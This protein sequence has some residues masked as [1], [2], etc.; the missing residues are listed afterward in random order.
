MKSSNEI[1]YPVF[2]TNQI[3][4]ST[5]L[6][7]LREFLDNE[8][9]LTRINIGGSGII[10]GLETDFVAA[11][12]LLTVSKGYGI[13]SD[14]HFIT[15]ETELLLKR[16]KIY[17]LPENDVYAPF[18]KGK[19][20]VEI[21]ELFPDNTKVEGTQPLSKISKSEMNKKVVVLFLE[22]FDERLNTCTGSDCDNKGKRR[23]CSVKVLLINQADLSAVNLG[24]YVNEED[25]LETIVLPTLTYY[26]GKPLSDVTSIREI[27]T[28]YEKIVNEFRKKLSDAILAAHSKY[29]KYFDLH[30]LDIKPA[31]Q[32]KAMTFDKKFSQ[33][34]YDFIRDLILAYNEF[35]D[36]AGYVYREAVYNKPVF[37]RH[38]MLSKVYPATASSIES[39]RNYFVNT[40]FK[41]DLGNKTLQAQI[42]FKRILLM[43]DSF[44]PNLLSKKEIKITPS[45]I[46]SPLSIEAIPYY[47]KNADKIFALWNAELEIKSRSEENLSYNIT[48]SQLDFVKDPL[49][50]RY[51]DKQYY[52]IEGH[53]GMD[54]KKVVDLLEDQKQIYNLDF[55]VIGLRLGK[56]SEIS[57]IK[58]NCLFYRYQLE[59]K[60][61]RENII[62]E[63]DKIIKSIEKEF[64]SVSGQSITGVLL[65]MMAKAS[66]TEMKGKT[67]P[68]DELIRDLTIF[69]EGWYRVFC[70]KD[71]DYKEY[72]KTINFILI[73]M[74]NYYYVLKFL[75]DNILYKLFSNKQLSKL[76]ILNLEILKEKVSTAYSFIYSCFHRKILYLN[77]FLD[78]AILDYNQNNM[79][80]FPNF[81]RR[82]PGLDHIAGVR[83]GGTFILVYAQEGERNFA[84]VADFS[85]SNDY[86][87]ECCDKPLCEEYYLPPFAQ[88]YFAETT[89]NDWIAIKLNSCDDL[90]RNEKLE[91]NIKSI[92]PKGGTLIYP[93]EKYPKSFSYFPPKEGFSE[94]IDIFK[95]T[96]LDQRT[97]LSS[98]AFVVVSFLNL[99]KQHECT[100]KDI[101]IHVEEGKNIIVK[102]SDAGVEENSIDFEYNKTIIED[103]KKHKRFIYEII[104]SAY[105][106]RIGIY[107]FKYIAFEI[108]AGK[109]CFAKI[110]LTTQAASPGKNV[111]IGRNK[112]VSV[113]NSDKYK[114]IVGTD[115]MLKKNIENVSNYYSTIES[116]MSAKPVSFIS[117]SMNTT[118]VEETKKLADP[119]IN[120]IKKIDKELAAS[121]ET[122]E[123][124]LRKELNLELLSGVTNTFLNTIAVN[125][126][127]LAPNSRASIYLKEDLDKK[128]KSLEES[129]T[130]VITEKINVVVNPAKINFKKVIS[131]LRK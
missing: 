30:D 88:T 114:T 39:Y 113:L 105:F 43:I 70:I 48:T 69:K 115:T 40:P 19:K 7:R 51:D 109:K 59:Y 72:S 79:S 107:T 29:A 71:F 84:V 42:L 26:L 91:V 81:V 20:Q 82:N 23:T 102:F 90:F 92:T 123:L 33:Y 111:I 32:L 68:S 96:V 8:N 64:K 65:E 35:R 103:V 120:E 12:N 50:F 28:G 94:A 98:S 110:I 74:F 93:D 36:T 77:S 22:F 97:K 49:Y 117:G 57:K 27:H 119:L 118:I 21:L 47:Y 67:F 16:Y 41:D 63:I 100:L 78:Q 76:E 1:C 25:R 6:N 13:T 18:I 106:W 73:K 121:G 122:P 34:A 3:L 38:L 53:L 83:K 108:A 54:Y 10:S 60:D 58:D 126:K 75:L 85:I 15:L 24:D 46:T 62:C 128:I 31:D 17:T 55:K 101:T 52:R 11:S 80:L 5:Q 66:G 44:D 116:E 99:F 61:I 56:P 45:T 37:P 9:R 124:K 130:G 104:P 14:G 131:I 86:S 87:N 2:E 127:D 112:L 95:Y 129:S 4:T 89:F 125:E